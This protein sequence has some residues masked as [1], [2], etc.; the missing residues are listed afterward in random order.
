MK[1]IDDYEKSNPLHSALKRILRNI[2]TTHWP[3]VEVFVPGEKL[4]KNCAVS[5]EF[6]DDIMYAKKLIK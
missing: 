2:N 3:Q 5:D 6:R 1:I 4:R